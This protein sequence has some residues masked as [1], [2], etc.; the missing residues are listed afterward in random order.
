MLAR[1]P[2]NARA[3]SADCSNETIVT[4]CGLP[5]SSTV[6]SCAPRPVTNF[7]ALSI[8][9]ASTRTNRT[10][11][12]TAGAGTP[13]FCSCAQPA[14]LRA[15]V[16]PANEIVATSTRILCH[17]DFEH[18]ILHLTRSLP[19]QGDNASFAVESPLAIQNSNDCRK[20]RRV[21]EPFFPP[22]RSVLSFYHSLF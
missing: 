19:P 5:S 8:T 17:H 6:K 16:T 15:N 7:P 1:W 21:R 13:E 3:S 11:T 4:F 22:T 12:R 2:R 18:F 20:P 10:D 9:M 14:E